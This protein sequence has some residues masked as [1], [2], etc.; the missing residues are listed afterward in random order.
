MAERTETTE[1][2]DNHGEIDLAG[3]ANVYTATTARAISGY[4]KGLRICGKANHT[5]NGATTLN[6]NGIGAVAVRKSGNTALVG[7][8]IVSGQYYDFLYETTNS[9]WQLLN[10]TVTIGAGSIGTTEL[11]DNAVTN[12][13][14]ADMAASTIKGRAVGAGTGDPT[15]LTPAQATAILDAFT[16]A[17]KGLVP[18]SG[19]GTTTFL[20]ADGTFAAPVAH[21]ERAYAVNLSSAANQDIPLATY[22]AFTVHILQMTFATDNNQLHVR[23]SDDNGSTFEAG[24]SDYAWSQVCSIA[25]SAVAESDDADSEIQIGRTGAG[26]GIGNA[27]GEYLTLALDIIPAAGARPKGLHWRGHY[28]DPSTRIIQTVGSGVFNG[29]TNPINYMRLFAAAGGNITAGGVFVFG[30]R[31]S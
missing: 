19:G 16:S 31:Y 6:V 8:E 5:N 20:R 29:N 9:V 1:V 26:N 28:K 22:D 2:Y 10:P 11:A 21:F 12:A 25:T 23:F 4:F 13:K 15:D 27:A 30:Y 18:A 14:L 7:G 3:A 24:A 17:L